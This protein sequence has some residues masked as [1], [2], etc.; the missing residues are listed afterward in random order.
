VSKDKLVKSKTKKA[1]AK[2]KG[3]A[4]TSKPATKKAAAKKK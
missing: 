4:G 3:E 2:P 1:P